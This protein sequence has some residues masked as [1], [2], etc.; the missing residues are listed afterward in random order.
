MSHFSER[1]NWISFN[2]QERFIPHNNP[3]EKCYFEN[4]LQKQWLKTEN[5]DLG[6]FFGFVWKGF[7]YL[8]FGFGPLS[9]SLNNQHFVSYLPRITNRTDLFITVCTVCQAGTNISFGSRYVSYFGHCIGVGRVTPSSSFEVTISCPTFP[10]GPE[11][12]GILGSTLLLEFWEKNI[13][14]KLYHSLKGVF[15][16]PS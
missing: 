10:K 4:V 8:A 11:L 7:H 12:A 14:F 6:F 16:K 13:F 1:Q 15:S 2:G 3:Y 5:L 9:F